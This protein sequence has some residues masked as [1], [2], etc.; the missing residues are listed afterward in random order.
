MINL[1]AVS[2]DPM[3]KEFDATEEINFLANIKLAKLSKEAGVKKFIFASN[4]SVYGEGLAH[5]KG[6]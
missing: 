2:N 6:K 3:G 4:C 5:P 1:A